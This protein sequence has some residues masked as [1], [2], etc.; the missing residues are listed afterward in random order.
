MLQ[1]LR[2]ESDYQWKTQGVEIQR[3][4]FVKDNAKNC[5]ININYVLVIPFINMFSFNLT[6]PLWNS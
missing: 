5:L 1:V 2:D 4:W 6:T 3:R